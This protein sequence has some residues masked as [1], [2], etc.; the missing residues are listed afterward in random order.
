MTYQEAIEKLIWRKTMNEE[1]KT[2][3]KN[4]TWE[5]IPLIHDKETI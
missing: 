4:D 5:I 3:E 2:L 1:L